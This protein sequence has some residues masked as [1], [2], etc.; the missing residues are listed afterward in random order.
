MKIYLTTILIPL[1]IW[2]SAQN[3]GVN[4][5]NP[6]QPLEVG[7]IIFTNDGGVMFPDS[8]VQTTAAAANGTNDAA[9]GK[10]FGVLRVQD[11]EIDIL[12]PYNE[13]PY[14]DAFEVLDM[15]FSITVELPSG[16]GGGGASTPQS[17]T[18]DVIIDIDKGM[19]KWYLALISGELLDEVTIDLLD[20]GNDAYY[21]YLLEDC[22][23][24]ELTP[25]LN[26]RGGDEFAHLYVAKINCLK[27]TITDI[28]NGD[29]ACWDYQLNSGC[30][31]SP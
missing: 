24:V 25:Y 19:T 21:Q 22:R 2:A 1:S 30:A 9:N 11:G 10:S 26:Y 15:L 23:L 18:V 12:G 5:S 7:G 6:T 16:G 14:E 20:S 31:C 27:I 4:Q 17:S 29:C 3:V 28:E 13:M 8:S